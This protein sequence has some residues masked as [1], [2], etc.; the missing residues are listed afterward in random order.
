[1]IRKLIFG[2][3]YFGKG[4]ADSGPGE[5]E[6]EHV[7]SLSISLAHLYAFCVI[8]YIPW[9]QWITDFDGH[10]KIL[11]KVILS[12]RKYQDPLIDDRIQ[13]WRNGT[14]NVEDDLLDVLINH[15][16]PRLTTDQIKAQCLELMQAVVDNP[17]NSIKWAM[18]EMINQPR[19]FD[20]AVDELDRVVGKN[21]LVQES[22]IPNLNYIKACVREAFRV[23][24]VGPFNLARMTTADSTVAGYY[25][26]KGSHVIVSR[27]GLGRNLEV[28]DDPLSF[29]PERHTHGYNQ[30][31]LTDN[32][33][34]MFSFGT[35]PRGCAGVLLGTTMTVMM[36]A[37]LLQ[38]FTWE[39]PPNEPYVD[40]KEN[41]HNL[42]KAKPLLAL[43]KPRLPHH[44]YPI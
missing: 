8:D 12:I 16:N 17:S 42:W 30:V 10:E 5:E 3:M 19:I 33:L 35:G 34:H 6:I 29:K 25:I 40:L 20:K 27:L 14:R 22:D 43:A 37:R 38:R 4:S 2:H 7:D 1:M 39:L 15:D 44:L 31:V 13:Q 32:N 36:L 9:L 21:R 11:R 18:A 23:H 41:M 26:P 24:P 28:W